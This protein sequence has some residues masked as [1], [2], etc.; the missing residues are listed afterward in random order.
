MALT[1][2]SVGKQIEINE[3]LLIEAKVKTMKD[4]KAVEAEMA[5]RGKSLSDHKI[6]LLE[7]KDGLEV[8]MI[9]VGKK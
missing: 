4:G 8:T 1:R 2:L 3:E 6:E 7:A 9:Y 5:S